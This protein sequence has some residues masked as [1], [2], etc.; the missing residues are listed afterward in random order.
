METLSACP[1]GATVSRGKVPRAG[2][3]FA[4]R[5]LAHKTRLLLAPL[6]LA[7]LTMWV[8]PLRI[9]GAFFLCVRAPALPVCAPCHHRRVNWVGF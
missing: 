4:H 6:S 5:G 1:R 8:G 9:A 7:L 2:A 3:L